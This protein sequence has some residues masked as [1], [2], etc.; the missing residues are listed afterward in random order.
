MGSVHAQD[1]DSGVSGAEPE[2]TTRYWDLLYAQRGI[3]YRRSHRNRPRACA[4]PAVINRSRDASTPHG[5]PGGRKEIPQ[6]TGH[7]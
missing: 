7:A 1:N 5:I 3:E 4:Y 2:H 6:V